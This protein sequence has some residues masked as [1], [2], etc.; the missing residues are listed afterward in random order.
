MMD[1]RATRCARRPRSSR[2]SASATTGGRR[3]PRAAAAARARRASSS[4]PCCSGSGRVA[5]DAH[6]DARRRRPA[7]RFAS[8]ASASWPSRPA[9]TASSAPARR[10][11]RTTQDL[12]V[13]AGLPPL[14]REGDRF[15][16]RL[17][18]AQHHRGV[19]GRDAHARG[20]GPR[21]AALAASTRARGR[22]G[23]RGRLARSRCRPASRRC[24]SSSTS[25]S[26]GGRRRPRADRGQRVVPAVPERVLQATLSSSRRGRRS[27]VERPADA[28]PGRGGVAVALRPRLADGSD[29]IERATARVPVHCPR[30]ARRASRSR[31]ATTRAG[32]VIDGAARLPRR[33][34][35]RASFFPGD[36]PGSD[37]LTTLRPLAR[38][39]GAATCSRR[40]A[41]AHARRARALR[42]RA[43]SDGEPRC[44]SVD[45]PLR[46][47]AALRSA[48]ALRQATPSCSAASRVAPRELAERGAARLDRDPRSRARAARPR[49]EA[50]RGRAD[51]ARAPRGAG[52]DARLLDERTDG[53]RLAARHRPRSNRRAARARAPRAP[54]WRDDL[55]RS[56]AARS[57]ANARRLGDD[58]RER[59]GRARARALLG[60]SSRRTP[61]TG[62]TAATLADAKRELA[63]AADAEGRRL[64]LPWPG[65]AQRARAAARRRRRAV[66]GGAEPRC[67]CRSARRSTPAT[68]SS[69]LVEPVTQKTAGVWSRGDVVRVRVAIVAS[70]ATRA[71]SSSSDPIPAGATLLGSGL[72]G[73][74][75]L[76]HRRRAAGRRATPG[77]PSPSARLR[78]SAATTS[79]CRRAPSR[80][81]TRVRLNQAGHLPAAR[82]RASRRCTRPRD[83]RV[84]ERGR[85]GR[86]V[87]RALSPARRSTP[88]QAVVVALRRPRSGRRRPP[89]FGSRRDPR[90]LRELGGGAPRPP[91]R[92]AARAARR[93]ARAAPRVDAARRVAPGAA[94]ER[95]RERGPALPLAR[96]RRLDRGARRAARRGARAAAP[97]REHAHHAARR[98]PRSRRCAPRRRGAAWRRSGARC[99]PR[100]RSSGA[101]RRTRS[102][103]P[104]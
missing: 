44:R 63:W 78:P 55:P 82:R 40:T 18:A 77:R 65:G 83:R 15:R 48:R 88:S 41:R 5:L 29:A 53:A 66:G 50:R 30:A 6:G 103:R 72:G 67:A 90:A 25:R 13:L 81:S 104:I 27:P 60:A 85:R 57:R 64:D 79:T 99:A 12:M 91:R 43:R 22:R 101:S 7:E 54:A 23:A 74:S 20:R 17:H 11:I 80:S 102:S 32:A 2:W 62:T 35:A 76:A 58:D 68:R 51:P 87:K 36:E 26:R 8:R 3:C 73:D 56:C 39:R 59:L 52:H 46:K 33:Q 38:G 19:A 89:H 93:P 28:L 92:R 31:C 37:V 69:A 75:A 42:R 1:R 24:R 61:V 96:R 9:P 84:P 70:I 45:L 97:R 4:T 21:R 95:G 94:R 47:L 98:P 10:A 71:G 49:G 100:A 14:V 34:R 16:G 86:A